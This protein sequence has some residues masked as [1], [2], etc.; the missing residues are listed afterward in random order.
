MEQAA[1]HA[2]VWAAGAVVQ[3][4]AAFEWEEFVAAAIQNSLVAVVV[5]LEQ[6]LIDSVE[7]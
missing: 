3:A 6:G 7:Y 4:V 5:A 1:A 2:A